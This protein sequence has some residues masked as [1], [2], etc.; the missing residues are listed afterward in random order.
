VPILEMANSV[1]CA[2]IGIGDVK[3]SV[4]IDRG[5]LTAG[6]AGNIAA[7]GAV[8]DIFTHFFDI[9]GNEVSTV[10]DGRSITADVPMTCPVV[11]VAHGGEKV[12]PIVGAIR[13]K[14]IT[15]LVTDEKTALA[16]LGLLR[17]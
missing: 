1:E 14:L 16:V 5:F 7:A 15:G 9:D 11:V 6:D 2:M 12:S 13:G 4:L 10:L 17:S 8:G 3:N